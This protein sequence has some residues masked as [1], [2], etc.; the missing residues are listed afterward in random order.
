MEGQV[1]PLNAPPLP[2]SWAEES[3]KVVR[4]PAEVTDLPVLYLCDLHVG[5]RCFDEAL[6]D[7]YLAKAEAN[8]V[9]RILIGGDL[10]EAANRKS[11]GRVGDQVMSVTEQ[12]K[13]LQRR[14]EP[15]RD[16]TDGAVPGNHEERIPNEGGDDE[17]AV[18]CELLGIDY[19]GYVGMIAYAT[20]K[21]NNCAY[22]VSFRHGASNALLPGG[23]VNAA[24]RQLWIDQADVYLSGHTHKPSVTTNMIRVPDLYAPAVR[25]KEQHLVTGGAL[26][27][28][29]KSYAAMKGYPIAKPCQAIVTLRMM[30]RNRK[31]TVDFD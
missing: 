5:H 19:F 16:R 31:V 25:V 18:L 3:L 11:P 14:L 2:Q 24:Q 26:L 8:P 12:R 30:K 21:S 13:Y 29:W 28:P 1:T 7:Y 20:D 22:V 9:M 23:A 10:F 15:F 6:L 17:M 27:N 4:I